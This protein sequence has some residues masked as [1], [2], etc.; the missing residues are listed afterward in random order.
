MKCIK[1]GKENTEWKSGEIYEGLDRHHNPPKY[2]FK[3][4][5]LSGIYYNDGTIEEEWTGEMYILCR[6]CHTGKN[7]LHQIIII[8]YLLKKS[9]MLKYNGNE[10]WIWKN[11]LRCDRKLIREEIFLLSKNWVE[12]GDSKTT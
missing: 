10:Q 1:C 4:I 3:P 9:G 7:G 11:I 6:D 8:P 2:M 5:N 12:N